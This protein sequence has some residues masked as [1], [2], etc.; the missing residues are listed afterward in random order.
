MFQQVLVVLDR[1]AAD[2]TIPAAALF[3]RFYN[4]KLSLLH[5]ET[6]VE[7]VEDT[8]LLLFSELARSKEW[9]SV[10]PTLRNTATV[11]TP[12]LI[13]PASKLKVV[14]TEPSV[15]NQLQGNFDQVTQI[16]PQTRSLETAIADVAQLCKANLII[17]GLSQPQTVTVAYAALIRVVNCP[18]LILK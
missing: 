8:P 11:A 5:V 3:S 9:P 10:D 2:Q 17:V 15:L 12:T 14:G 6:V 18:V 16:F 1:H 7:T 4:S 13:R